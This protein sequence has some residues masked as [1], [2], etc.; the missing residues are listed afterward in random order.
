M[1]IMEVAENIGGM[2][3]YLKWDLLNQIND[4][5]IGEDDARMI[6]GQLEDLEFTSVLVQTKIDRILRDG[7]KSG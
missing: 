4:E 5:G 1:N 6:E 2:I 3:R 7:R